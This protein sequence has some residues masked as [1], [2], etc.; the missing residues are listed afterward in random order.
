M[1]SVSSIDQT[2]ISAVDLAIA[3]SVEKE[4]QH[5]VNHIETKPEHGITLKQ[6]KVGAGKVESPSA[7]VSALDHVGVSSVDLDIAS[8]VEKEAESVTL[9][10]VPDNSEKVPEKEIDVGPHEPKGI[11]TRIIMFYY[12]YMYACVVVVF[13]PHW[14]KN[15]KCLEGLKVLNQCDFISFFVSD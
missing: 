8:S 5:G 13:K 15:G 4:V 1:A 10:K 14:L 2:S 11:D 6:P 3:T 7:A 9:V 12:L